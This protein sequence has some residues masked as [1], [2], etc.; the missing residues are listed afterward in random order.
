MM[1][2]DDFTKVE[3]RAEEVDKSAAPFDRLEVTEAEALEH[4]Q[5]NVRLLVSRNFTVSNT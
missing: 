1:S 5:H 3:A 2:Q 4:L